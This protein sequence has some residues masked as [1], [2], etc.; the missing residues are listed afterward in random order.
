MRPLLTA[1]H[2]RYGTI[3]SSDDR[4]HFDRPNPSGR[5]VARTRG[6][7]ASNS[8]PPQIQEMRNSPPGSR[9]ATAGTIERGRRT[10]GL[11]SRKR[12]NKISKPSAWLREPV[13]A[14][15]LGTG[16]LLL[17]HVRGCCSQGLVQLVGEFAE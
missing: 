12:Q 8:Y 11:F 10:K 2:V 17:G 6:F 16:F 3:W 7:T 15:D 1:A 14:E 4:P 5:R 13:R 9:G